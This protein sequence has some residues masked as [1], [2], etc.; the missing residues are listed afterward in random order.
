MKINEVEALVGIPKKNIRFYESE[1]LLKPERSSNG[2]RDYSEEEAEILR[3]IKLLRKLG[4]PLEE[5]RKMQS[6]THTVGDGMRRHLITLERDMEN[7]KQSIQFCSALADCRERLMD[8][9]AAA[10]LAEMESMELSGTTFQN[11]QRQDVRIRYVA[12]VTITLLTVL[13]MGGLAALIL[14]GTSVDPAGAVLV[15]MGMPAVVIGGVVLALFQ[16][17]QEI[18][19]GEEDDARQF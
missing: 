2:Y 10:L 5:I 13:L 19:K 12:P 15:L 9:D 6:G 1:G 14:W 18:G 4:V 11:K 7:L 3:R 17:I 8:L 16:R